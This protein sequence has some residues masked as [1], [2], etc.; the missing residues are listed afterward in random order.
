MNNPHYP[1]S[2]IPHDG[3]CG[4][5]C[6][7]CVM[8]A[9]GQKLGR[10]PT[11]QEFIDQFKVERT[12]VLSA[13]RNFDDAIFVQTYNRPVDKDFDFYS[14]AHGDEDDRQDEDQ[15]TQDPDEDSDS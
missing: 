1:K 7:G 14:L 13:L 6:A 10:Q 11:D 2:L 3:K 4:P 9:L 12:V 5:M 15:F 8:G